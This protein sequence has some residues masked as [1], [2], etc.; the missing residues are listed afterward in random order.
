MS[1][2]ELFDSSD[3][4]DDPLW[5]QAEMMANAPPRPAKDY[6]ICSAAYLARVLPILLR[7]ERLA[8]AL[9]I[10]R[11]CLIKRSRTIDLSNA[12]LSELGIGRMTKYRSLAQLREAGAV[13]TEAETGHSIQ[14]TLHWFP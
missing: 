10:Y 13:T 6:F 4:F 12:M 1:D 2:D 5:Q 14:V 3:P 11:Q 7:S 8:V 9:V